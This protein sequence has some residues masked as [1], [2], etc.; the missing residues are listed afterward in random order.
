MAT[1]QINDFQFAIK[2][3]DC[4]A[5]AKHRRLMANRLDE[6]QRNHADRQMRRGSWPRDRWYNSNR[7]L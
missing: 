3:L 7:P 1:D 5:A 6:I 4:L 2:I